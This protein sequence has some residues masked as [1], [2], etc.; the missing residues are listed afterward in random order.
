M[1]QGHH[2][3]TTRSNRVWILV[4]LAL[5]LQ[6]G[7]CAIP[8]ERGAPVEERAAA[9]TVPSDDRQAV[10]PEEEGGAVIRPLSRDGDFW[11]IERQASP[12]PLETIPVEPVPGA[13]PGWT[14]GASSGTAG[15]PA[16]AMPPG[17]GFTSAR[18][19]SSSGAVVALLDSAGQ[20]ARTGQLDASAASLERA[21]RI[22]PGNPVI[23][24]RL[25]QVR[26]QQGRPDQ[27]ESLA[28]KS[29]MLA[30]QD[31]DLQ[32]RNWRIIAQARRSQGNVQGAR[33]A[34]ERAAEL[35][36]WR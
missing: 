3:V 33:A 27:A 11:T 20:Q 21:L 8:P 4:A 31:P 10:A 16:G 24:S 19:P 13:L 25:A 22:E 26:L 28:A 6:L 5:G 36:G 29:N 30:A 7:G 9:G 18:T 12:Q 32:A 2:A 1:D 14:P 17:D 34:E 23:W 15:A 35:A